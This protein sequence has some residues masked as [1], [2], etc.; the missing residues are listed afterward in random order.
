M[1]VTNGNEIHHQSVFTSNF[2]SAHAKFSGS[3]GQ[4][5]HSRETMNLSVFTTHV[6][7]T[8]PSTGKC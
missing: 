6:P 5:S 3:Q 4:I 7:S 2:C 8:E 1:D